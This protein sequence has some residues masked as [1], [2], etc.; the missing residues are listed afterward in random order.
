MFV[1]VSPSDDPAEMLT[2]MSACAYRLGMAFGREAES[3]EDHARKVELLG[4]FERCFFS[5]R[6]ATALRLRL[7]R[8]PAA[9]EARAT[10]SAAQR[11]HLET[12]RLETDPSEIERA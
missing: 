9:A 4:L 2:A 6:V 5:V 12:E 11:E 1:L 8:E 7:G 3:A 10:A